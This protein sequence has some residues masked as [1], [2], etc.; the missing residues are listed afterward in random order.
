MTSNISQIRCALRI[1]R[2]EWQVSRYFGFPLHV[3][4]VNA[5]TAFY[6]HR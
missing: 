1:A 4:I 3:A 6:I 5:A 2:V